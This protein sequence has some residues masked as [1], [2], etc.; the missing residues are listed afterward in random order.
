[1]Q[2]PQVRVTSILVALHVC[3][4]DRM[5]GTAHR[6]KGPTNASPTVEVFGIQVRLDCISPAQF[7]PRAQIEGDLCA[8]LPTCFF[9]CPTCSRLLFSRC[10][11]TDSRSHQV[12]PDL[13]TTSISIRASYSRPTVPDRTGTAQ[14]RTA[15][16]CSW[17]GSIHI[18]SNVPWPRPSLKPRTNTSS[19]QQHNRHHHHAHSAQT[20]HPHRN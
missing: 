14:C 13:T 18:R 2:D 11:A 17:S 7:T 9:P 3:S 10:R 12:K 8:E 15:A 20:S 4:P 5:R 6:G 1:M 19:T 16:E